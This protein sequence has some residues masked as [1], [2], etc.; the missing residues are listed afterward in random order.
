M[1]LTRAK[2]A[3]TFSNIQRCRFS[4]ETDKR[5]IAQSV[6]SLGRLHFVIQCHALDLRLT[7][8]PALEQSL[9]AE[10]ATV[11]TPNRLLIR[12]TRSSHLLIPSTATATQR[13]MANLAPD[14]RR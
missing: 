4:S 1:S 11:C 12:R 8:G 7:H 13:P 6:L 2:A 14:W 9:A 10:N 5:L 3:S